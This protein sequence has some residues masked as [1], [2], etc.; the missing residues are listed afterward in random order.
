MFRLKLKKHIKN[1]LIVT[2]ILIVLGIIVIPLGFSYA[3]FLKNDHLTNINFVAGNLNYKIENSKLTN[4]S[5]T[6]DGGEDIKLVLSLTSL[7]NIESKYELYYL[8]DGEKKKSDDIEIGYTSESVDSVK[9]LIK[10]NSKKEIT[11]NIKNKG[12][13]QVIITFGAEGGLVSNE[14]VMVK[15]NSLDKLILG[16]DIMLA[17]TY[18]GNGQRPSKFPGIDDGYYI[19]DLTCVGGKASWNNDTWTMTITETS[20]HN[21]S[22]NANV[23]DLYKDNSGASMPVLEGELIPVIINTDGSVKKASPIEEW[24]NYD[25]S[26]WANAV[27]L[28][29]GYGPYANNE[30]IP[31][32]AI[33]SYFVWI[34]RYKYKIFDEGNYST[35]TAT[36]AKEQEIEI[37]FESKSIIASTGS[38]AGTWLTHPAF[39]SFNSEGFWV[40][41]FEAGYRDAT[42][43]SGAQKNLVEPEN[44]VIKPNNYIWANI[45]LANAFATSYEYMRDLD[46]HMMKN[47][48]WGA[49]A[50]L[51]HSKYGAKDEDGNVGVSL[52]INNNRT[53]VTGYS[54]TEEPTKSYN[55]GNS[56]AGNR[57]V[58]VNPGVD[59]TYSVN[60]FNPLSVASSTTN[61][62]SGIYDMAGGE[63]EYV[64]GYNEQASTV[65]GSSGILTLH[66]DFFTNDQ[67]SKYYD[68]Y[69]S[70]SSSM[71]NARILG[72]AT[73]E[74]G[75]FVQ[76]TNQSGDSKPVISSWYKDQ[77]NFVEKTNPWFRRGGYNADGTNAG[78]FSYNRDTGAKNGANSYRVVLTPEKK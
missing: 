30:T 35:L 21:I 34:P 67:W 50:Y 42:S 11:V 69:S 39:T 9:G 47:T 68:L 65:A 56:I 16:S 57:T 37:S 66:S 5:I 64:M 15:G 61:N 8:L 32:E 77:A 24:Y 26:I 28:N 75:P 14:L 51:S 1:R 72:D 62:Y 78:L 44:L 55:A 22:C 58:F 73:G 60:Y 7:N 46:S 74:L 6:V 17:Y 41:K 4:N 20:G 19:T 71:N 70:S 38:T 25:N 23:V 59:N 45:S 13:K 76:I 63:C 49:V 31:E 10:A 3:I 54:G 40:G 36:E 18:V 43:T 27:I 12:N 2:T 33:E 53:L 48:E 52:R 29:W